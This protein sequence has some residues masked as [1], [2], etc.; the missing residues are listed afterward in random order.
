MTVVMLLSLQVLA[1]CGKSDGGNTGETDNGTTNTTVSDSSDAVPETTLDENAQRQAIS[2][3]LPAMDFQGASFRIAM[4]DEQVQYAME[5]LADEE[6]GEVVNDAVYKRNTEI[7]SRFNIKF[8]PILCGGGSQ[9]VVNKLRT[10]IRAGSD[11]CD[12]FMSH[13]IR[14]SAVVPEGLYVDWYSLPEIN[15]EKPWWNKSALDNLTVGG[16]TYLTLGSANLSALYG[17]YC[18]FFN[19]Q[20]AQDNGIGTI[21]LYK[22]ILEGKWTLEKLAEISKSAYKDLNGDAT[23]GENDQFGLIAT[24]ESSS[25]AFLWSSNHPLSVRGTDGYPEMQLNQERMSGIVDKVYDLY[26]NNEGTHVINSGNNNDSINLFKQGNSLFVL[27]T[28]GN[29][30]GLRDAEFEYGIIPYPKYDESQDNYYTMADGFHTLVGIPTNA[31]NLSMSAIITEALNAYS[32]KDVIPAYYEVALKVKY[33]RDDESVQLLDI[34]TEGTVYDFG[35][36]YDD[37]KGF[38]FMMQDLMRGKN[39][40]FASYYESRL[41]AAE[42]QFEKVIEAYRGLE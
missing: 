32:Y 4:H 24:T 3:D 7:E 21:D 37:W 9:E 10:N 1:S 19:K 39:N 22:T 27:N 30:M 28:I 25:V 18:I 15:F 20:L 40:N 13:A 23:I 6:I 38:G 36:F 16:R 11:F 33:T 14:T 8:E 2:D 31:P 29:S 5:I 41:N 12:L 34:I 17:T 42:T 35:Y 26:Y